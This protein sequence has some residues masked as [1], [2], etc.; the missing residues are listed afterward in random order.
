MPFGLKNAGATYQRLIEKVFTHL[1]GK[2][3]EIYVDDMVVK[4]PSHLQHS[5]DLPKVFTTL[6]KYNLRLNPNKCVFDIDSRKFL[7]FMLT[8]HGIEANPEKCKAIIEM[9]SPVNIKEVQRLVGCLTAIS[10]FLPKLADKTKP[11]IHLLKKSAKFAWNDECNHIFQKLKATL[12]SPPILQKPDTNL[13]LIVYITA[14]EGTVSAAITQE[15]AS[16]QYLVYFVSQSLQD[17]ETKYQIVE[18]L[19]LSLVN[20]ARWLR[21]YFHNHQVIVR[22]D[23]P[24]Q[25]ILQ[26]PD[27]AGQ[28]SS[29]VVEL[30]EF[31]IRYELH[32]PVKAQCLLD[33][34]ND[35]QH[36][37][38]EE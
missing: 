16:T 27:L 26:K 4:S 18:K 19:D 22:T 9:P 29:W 37:P 33:F 23:Y 30:S 12:A 24:I 36:A 25:K 21:P 20:V 31:N 14:T 3:V 38:Q 11:I 28:M 17:P 8:Q 6:R 1:L 13:P 7:G 35:L 15:Y 5:K 34:V 2:C 32:G 10:R